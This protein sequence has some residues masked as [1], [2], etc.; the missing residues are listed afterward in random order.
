[1]SPSAAP[2]PV[3]RRPTTSQ[4][5]D[6]AEI[7]HRRRGAIYHRTPITAYTSPAHSLAADARRAGELPQACVF[8]VLPLFCPSN[9]ATSLI[10]LSSSYPSAFAAARK[11]PDCTQGL[12]REGIVPCVNTYGRFRRRTLLVEPAYHSM[13]KRRIKSPRKPSRRRSTAHLA[14]FSEYLRRALLSISR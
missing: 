14:S 7:R 12:V 8:V 3:A 9:E 2:R 13:A 10:G 6:S 11:A 5:L 1:M 4:E